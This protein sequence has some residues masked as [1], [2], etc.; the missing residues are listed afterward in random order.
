MTR[1]LDGSYT[2]A[3]SGRVTLEL[4][5]QGLRFSREF[6]PQFIQRLK[7]VQMGVSASF[8][9]GPESIEAVFGSDPAF[10]EKTRVLDPAPNGRLVKAILS[11]L[12]G[13][14]PQ[15]AGVEIDS[16]WGAYVD[17]TPDAVP[18]VSAMNSFAGLFLAAGC[19]GHG[20]G[21]GPGIGYLAA[22][23]VANEAPS[24]DPTHFRL[25]RLID[26]S[27]IKVGSL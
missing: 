17:C 12:R 21:L 23:L 8:V 14:F 19:S 9:N 2:V 26:G 3:I 16:A 15:L 18:V 22:E 11:N 25:E 20:F 1:R 24:I 7:A 4:T 6:M 27:R 10:F 5:P 13:T